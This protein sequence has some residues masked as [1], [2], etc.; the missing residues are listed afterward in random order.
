MVCLISFRIKV[1]FLRVD[2]CFRKVFFRNAVR[3]RLAKP[4]GKRAVFESRKLIIN[5]KTSTEDF[6]IRVFQ[7]A[8]GPHRRKLL[9]KQ[10]Q[11]DHAAQSQFEMVFLNK[12]PNSWK[13]K[14]I[15]QWITLSGQQI[16]S[17]SV[18]K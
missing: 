4:H 1:R 12:Q 8:E 15:F 10:Q 5:L 2:A 7:K 17:M 18:A 16:V 11:D 13:D 9:S 14:Y 6:T 3:A